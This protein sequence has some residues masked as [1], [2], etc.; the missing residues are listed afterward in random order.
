MFIDMFIDS[1]IPLLLYWWSDGFVSGGGGGVG[2]SGAARWHKVVHGIF[3]ASYSLLENQNNAESLD[4]KNP[5]SNPSV[6]DEGKRRY[7]VLDKECWI[8]GVG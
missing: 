4:T 5:F 1:A 3:I 8:R 7:G 2:G 6:G